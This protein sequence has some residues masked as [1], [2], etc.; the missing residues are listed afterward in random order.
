MSDDRQTDNPTTDGADAPLA[1]RPP[2]APTPDQVAAGLT[3][4][5]LV[6]RR[7]AGEA[8]PHETTVRVLA[9]ARRSQGDFKQDCDR[10]AESRR[11]NKEV[12]A[13]EAELEPRRAKHTAERRQY[14]R[15]AAVATEQFAARRMA[16]QSEADELRR[17]SVR[18]VELRERIDQLHA[19]G[20]AGSDAADGGT[21]AGRN[22]L[23]FF[24]ARD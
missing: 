1:F 17:L 8:I 9:A 19:G 14:D 3:Y 23:H 5:E 22:V 4:R 7:A 20:K 24:N 2:H 21:V 13:L 18:L 15:E 12:L 16:L 6:R 10:L 11:L